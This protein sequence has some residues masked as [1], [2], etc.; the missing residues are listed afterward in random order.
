MLSFSHRSTDKMENGG[1]EAMVR[2]LMDWR[3]EDH[4][5]TWESLRAPP[6]TAARYAQVGMGM[7]GPMARLVD[8]IEAGV[9]EG[10]TT[11]GEVFLYELADDDPTD[12][13]RQ[14][15]NAVLA[16]G[17]VKYGRQSH[18]LA[19]AIRLVLG[20]EAESGDRKKNVEYLGVLDRE[21]GGD[22]NESRKVLKTKGRYVTF[23]P[24]SLLR[25]RLADFGRG[26]VNRE[27]VNG[28]VRS[29][30]PIGRNGR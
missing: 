18:E 4:D 26:R 9:L 13:L 7:E 29:N 14:H 5:L 10:R 30:S 17:R 3:P 24:I 11:T 8:T 6:E 1:V 25:Q 16:D 27:P 28:S 21:V 22:T 20:A 12:V 15:L 23:P 19:E 2:E